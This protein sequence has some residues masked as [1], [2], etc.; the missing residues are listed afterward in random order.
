LKNRKERPI[1]ENANIL[2]HKIWQLENHSNNNKKLKNKIIKIF[3]FDEK[4]PY[5]KNNLN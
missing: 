1:T 5:S 2:A 3:G 4:N